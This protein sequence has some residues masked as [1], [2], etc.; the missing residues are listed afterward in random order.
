MTSR[1]IHENFKCL[2]DGINVAFHIKDDL[3]KASL[4]FEVKLLSE[5]A[6]ATAGYMNLYADST[7][8]RLNMK[9]SVG[10]VHEVTPYATDVI[11]GIV[12][13]AT[14]GEVAT[15]TDTTRVVTCALIGPR[16]TG[17][18]FA[19]LV[20]GKIPIGQLPTSAVGGLAFHSFWNAS[21]NSP[22]VPADASTVPGNFYIV[23]VAGSTSLSG[24]TDWKI[25]DWV[26]SDG[27][28]WGKSDN[29][30]MSNMI[31]GSGDIQF[32][33][34]SNVIFHVDVADK[35]VGINDSAP[36]STLSVAPL[37][38][39]ETRSSFIA[40]TFDSASNLA[41]VLAVEPDHVVNH[42]KRKTT[43]VIK[44]ETVL[45]SSAKQ[46]VLF[47]DGEFMLDI[48]VFSQNDTASE[49]FHFHGVYH[50]S[51]ESD[52][53]TLTKIQETGHVD[54]FTIVF[55]GGTQDQLDLSWAHTATS[56]DY[57]IVYSITGFSDFGVAPVYHQ[58]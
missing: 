25:G 29:S 19:T 50:A 34:T 3:I 10:N 54:K 47:P 36:T 2:P 12:E 37:A 21:T 9:D 49:T 1:V 42:S 4:P 55:N 5:P 11:P 45:V 8:K 22:T 15:G 13:I 43:K 6:N 24:I 53:G 48:K 7:Y 31:N 16:G 20:G 41:L 26:V 23:N 46:N 14:S 38:G 33:S 17:E 57:T 27:T 30:E 18:G 44:G 28:N 52:V 56:C 58:A 39:Q 40:K 32:P 35:S 51:V